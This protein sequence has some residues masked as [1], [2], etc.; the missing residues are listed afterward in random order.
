MQSETRQTGTMQSD[1]AE[2]T[3][4]TKVTYIVYITLRSFFEFR[5]SLYEH[6]QWQQVRN[7]R[8]MCHN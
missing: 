3:A 6:E 2:D 4:S 7:I 5:Q 8:L 1:E